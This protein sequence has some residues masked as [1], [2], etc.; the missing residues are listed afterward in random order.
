[1]VRIVSFF[2][3]L[4]NTFLG[5]VVVEGSAVSYRRDSAQPPNPESD[6]GA[7]LENRSHC[8]AVAASSV[9]TRLKSVRDLTICET[10][11]SARYGMPI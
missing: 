1:M 8:G 5:K 4:S 9:G 2:V 11:Q 3:G 7:G 6:T 10:Q